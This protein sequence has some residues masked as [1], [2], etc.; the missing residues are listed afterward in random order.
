M[1]VFRRAWADYFDGQ[2]IRYAF[3]SAANAK[4]IQE[5]RKEAEL[6][7][8]ELAEEQARGDRQESES[9]EEEGDG[10]DE[11]EKAVREEEE[12]EESEEEEGA[13]GIWN[14]DDGDPRTKVLSVLELEELFVKS[15]PDISSKFTHPFRRSQLRNPSPRPQRT[16]RFPCK[17]SSRPRRL[18][19]R[20][21][22]EHD[23]LPARREKSLRLIHARKDE[24][25]PDD[26][27]LA[28]YRAV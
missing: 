16:R 15:A 6:L 18:P 8:A 2:R 28:H 22:I 26:P 11:I 23:Q 4:A 27:P 12:G 9:S 13:H 14:D 10:E 24:A 7:A 19:K 5:A 21:Q 17:T 1:G 3:F 20:R 25:L